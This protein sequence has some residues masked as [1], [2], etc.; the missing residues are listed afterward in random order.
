[1]PIRPNSPKG[2]IFKARLDRLWPWLVLALAAW[3]GWKWIGESR[4]GLEFL[5]EGLY[6]LAAHDPWK[7]I[8][9]TQFGFALHPLYVAAGRDPGAYRILGLFPLLAAAWLCAVCLWR[10]QKPAGSERRLSWAATGLILSGALL[11]FSDGRRTP[12]YDYL[13]LIGALVGWAGFLVAD[14]TRGTRPLGWMLLAAGLL[15]AGFGKWAVAL[16]L[17]GLFACLLG[18]RKVPV[19]AG[20]FPF[21]ATLGAG[22]TGAFFWIGPEALRL[23][24]QESGFIVRELGSHGTHLLPYYGL[25]LVNFLYRALRAFAYGLPFLLLWWWLRRHR[26][27][28]T[29]LG[30]SVASLIPWLILVAGLFFGLARGGISS[31]SRVGSN[32]MAELLWLAAAAW[33]LRGRI[34]W[35][36]VSTGLILTPFLLGTGTGTALGDYVGH[37]VVFFQ[38]A[39]LGI[40]AG[41][42][43]AG[44]PSSRI[45]PFLWLGTALNLFRADASLQDPFRTRNYRECRETWEIPGAGSVGLDP[46]QKRLLAELQRRL[47]SAG[48]KTGDPIV[49]IGDMPGLVY[50]LGG[51]SPGTCWY[52]ASTSQQFSYVHA[53]LR[54]VPAEVRSRSF[55][56]IRENSPLFDR[57]RALLSLVERS[58]NPDFVVGPLPLETSTTR[59][60]VWKPARP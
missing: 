16:V 22:L 44:I 46:G 2:R 26:P 43:K 52:F 58:G 6:F 38:M 21:G 39:G 18:L 19:S 7:N 59:L 28:S 3:I 9:S 14:F 13:V 50:L 51:W 56:I 5:D 42:R 25:T 11:V 1:M 37:G 4:H 33:L 17:A 27:G 30:D 41:L 15:I 49:A 12:G 8:H 57:R 36:A 32:G 29:I 40:W 53:V 31:F 10:W 60:F 54:S 34:G 35:S 47:Q 45:L 55:L 20:F 48:F 24:W 23:S